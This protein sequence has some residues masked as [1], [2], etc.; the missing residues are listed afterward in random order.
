MTYLRRWPMYWN[1]NYLTKGHFVEKMSR[2][3][4][5]EP[6]RGD[7]EFDHPYVGTPEYFDED[8]NLQFSQ[9]AKDRG[10]D[11]FGAAFLAA[12]YGYTG[13]GSGKKQAI[14]NHI[15]EVVGNMS[16]EM[17]FVMV[18]V[19]FVVGIASAAAGPDAVTRACFLGLLYMASIY[20]GL[21]W[22]DNSLL[23]RH[24]NLGV[25]FAEMLAGRLSIFLFLL[26]WGM[27]LVGAVAGAAVIKLTGTS[28]IPVIGAPNA[29][30]VG[31]AWT[32]QF[33]I[34]IFIVLTV[35]DQF[36]AL[37][38]RARTFG[39]RANIG[40]TKESVRARP[41][42]YG[43]AAFAGV[44]FAF[45]KF[46]DF[47]GSDHFVYFGGALGQQFLGIA[48]PW[49][50]AAAASPLSG[51]WALYLFTPL[52]V[53][54]AAFL[55][56]WFFSWCHN[57]GSRRSSA[58]YGGKRSGKKSNRSPSRSNTGS[59]TRNRKAGSSFAPKQ[60]AKELNNAAW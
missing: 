28:A 18:K 45:L 46:G 27:G 50:Q 26:Y 13:T 3:E 41:L 38:G 9:E 23:P 35:L 32:V 7:G 17:L 54:L 22:G 49:G 2:R 53:G 48:R 36:S 33:L 8:S 16:K 4:M 14:W 52:C 40:A 34:G 10:I 21:N 57:N 30:S 43:A 11:T 25:T 24:G 5:E 6:L 55:I 51:A 12:P 37:N 1:Y 56:D 44:S 20:V 42:L 39:K 60:A 47:T 19:I 59:S 15:P 58:N 31:G 29:T